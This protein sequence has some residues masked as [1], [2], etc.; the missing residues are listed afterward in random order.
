MLLET[1]QQTV[2]DNALFPTDETVVI[3]VSGGADSLALLHACA[4]LRDAFGCTFHV[5]T[6]NHGLRDAATD[7][8]AF[9]QQMTARHGLPCTAGVADVPRLADESGQSI[10]TA[11]RHARY[12][13]LVR[14]ADDIGS[15]TVATAHHA[16]DQAETVIMH[17]LRGTGVQGLRGMALRAPVPEHPAY[18]LV[19]PLLPIRRAAIEAY[20]HQHALIPRDDASNRNT[21][22]LRNAIRHRILPYLEEF[23]PNVAM[24]LTQLADIITVED[25]YMQGRFAQV[26]LPQM[27]FGERVTLP[28]AIF[29]RWHAALQ[30]RALR[31]AT[32]H[33]NSEA[34]YTHIIAMID[35]ASSGAVGATVSLPGDARLRV[36]YDTLYVEPVSL[37]L[38][39]GDYWLLP[40]DTSRHDVA[41]PGVTTL[42][43][44]QL[45]ARR[46][47]AADAVARLAIPSG[48]RVTLRTRQPGDRFQPMGMGGRSRKLKD[49][50]IDRKIPAHLRDRLPLLCVDD[51]IGAVILPDAWGVSARCAINEN[52]DGS[53]TFSVRKLL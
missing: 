28:L 36:G 10:E 29:R 44:W 32:Q 5:A 45:I 2:Y 42:D 8:V 3:A 19:R 1:L 47:A 41:I 26:V 22:F 51:S 12:A 53:I 20:C 39:A 23:N 4:T 11:A 38:P 7:D 6:L 40:T 27:K 48:A 16:D 50:L 18:T 13:F 24:S 34:A 9:V 25:D 37:P 30:R 17:L 31:A 35:V 46:E 14:V 52:T 49:W 33:L 15:H 43:D 21:D